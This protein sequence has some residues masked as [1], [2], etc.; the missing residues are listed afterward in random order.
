MADVLI[1]RAA[2]DEYV[3]AMQWYAERSITA[4][5]G[6]EAAIAAAINSIAT[7][8]NWHP[9]CDDRH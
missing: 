2:D 3:A 5:L 7:Q 8:P 9:A 4:A 6:F 1:L